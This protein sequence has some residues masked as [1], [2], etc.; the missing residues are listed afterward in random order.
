[1]TPKQKRFVEEYPVDLNA[2]K[3]A[4]RAGLALNGKPP[5]TGFY[6]YA[7]VDPRTDRVFYVG[8]GSG[9]RVLAHSRRVNNGRVDNPE[10]ERLVTEILAEHDRLPHIILSTHKFSGEA[11]SSERKTIAAIGLENLTNISP[12][13]LSEEERVR[14]ESRMWLDRVKPFDVWLG[15]RKRSDQDI[16]MYHKIVAEMELLT[17]EPWRGVT[18]LEFK[19]P[20]EAQN[21]VHQSA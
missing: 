13:R 10:K 15:E 18:T 19:T 5:K 14:L 6:T 7:L 4:I 1:M 11:L 3:A 21:N 20:P 8:K 12:G 2:T 9:N 16:E 17:R